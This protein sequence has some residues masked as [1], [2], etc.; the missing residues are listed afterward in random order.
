M[1]T[2]EAGFILP[3]ALII[4][5]IGAMVVIGLLGYASGL[6]RAGGEDADALKE[7]YAADAG[8]AHVKNLLREGP[9]PTP[10][11]P[12]PT[13]EV[14][15]LEV[16][17]YRTPVATPNPVVPPPLPEPI[18][19]QLPDKLNE[20]HLVTLKSVP[21]GTQVNISWAFMPPLISA[22]PS[23]FIYKSEDM[24][25]PVTIC[26]PSSNVPAEGRQWIDCSADLETSEV[27]AYVVKFDPGTAIGLESAT[28]SED[29]QVCDTP[30]EPRFCLTTPPVDY[31]VIS[32]DYIVVSEV[33]DTTVTAYLR[34]MHDWELGD[35]GGISYTYSGG[36]VHTLSW[37]PYPPDPPGE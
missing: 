16:N 3:L 5:A 26:Q 25:A 33:G 30:T 9:L 20:I 36:E 27:G 7:L 31:G 21:E 28:F 34:Q 14:N 12:I 17:V 15:G 11:T 8:I 23:I 2:G 18:A 29:P 22:A 1:R 35:N 19:P 32:T 4:V 13:I 24:T 37:K 6:L 10:P